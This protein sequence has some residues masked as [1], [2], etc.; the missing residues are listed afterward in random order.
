M[1]ILIIFLIFFKKKYKMFFRLIGIG[2][3]DK[4]LKPFVE[5]KFFAGGRITI[6]QE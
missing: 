1:T 5:G 2:F 3:D 6:I 4:F